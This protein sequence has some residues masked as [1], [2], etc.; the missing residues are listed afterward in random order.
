MKRIFDNPASAREIQRLPCQT[1]LFRVPQTPC[2]GLFSV[3]LLLA[4]GHSQPWQCITSRPRPIQEPSLSNLQP[5]PAVLHSGTIHWVDAWSSPYDSN[6]GQYNC[7]NWV[8]V[9]GVVGLGVVGFAACV[10]GLPFPGQAIP[11]TDL[12]SNPSIRLPSTS[13]CSIWRTGDATALVT[14][15]AKSVDARSFIMVAD[16]GEKINVEQRAYELHLIEK[17]TRFK[18]QY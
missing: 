18:K 7:D 11:L 15:T 1:Q 9:L 3:G 2:V 10:A 5:P 6:S 14:R 8:V 16:L 17:L 4:L 13:R 12:E